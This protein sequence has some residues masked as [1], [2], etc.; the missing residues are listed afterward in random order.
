MAQSGQVLE[1]GAFQSQEGADERTSGMDR[2]KALITRLIPFSV[3]W[4]VLTCGIVW[5]LSLEGI[6]G[7][8]IFGVLTA[9]TYY[10]LDKSER[11][12][13]K[14]GVEH[15]RIDSATYLAERQMEMEQENRRAIV[16]AYIKHLE[17]DN[18][19]QRKLTG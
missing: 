8:L 19:G 2:S 17:G 15:H 12:D 5:K 1:L 3:V 9:F 4:L 10:K 18:N 14:H 7:F 16:Q 6:D 11:H 13:S